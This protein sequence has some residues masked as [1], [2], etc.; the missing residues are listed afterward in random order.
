V[1]SMSTPAILFTKESVVNSYLGMKAMA[2]CVF[3]GSDAAEAEVICVSSQP[4][5]T[6]IDPMPHDLFGPQ[7]L[8]A[9]SNYLTAKL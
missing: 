9:A 8:I 2:A 5:L 3:C 7:S 4:K 1:P 6:A